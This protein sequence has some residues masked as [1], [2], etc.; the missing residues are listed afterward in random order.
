MIL[1]KKLKKTFV[2]L[3]AFMLIT[4]FA[5]AMF[6][7]TEVLAA[8]ELNIST[9]Y[10]SISV[11]PTD[12]IRTSISIESGNGQPFT[13]DLNVVS[14]PEGWE[15]YF[16]GGSNIIHSI[17]SDGKYAESFY[18]NIRMPY[19][20]P[21]GK[22]KV[23]IKGQSGSASDTL[24]LEYVVEAEMDNQGKLSAN[25][26]ELKGPNDAAFEFQIDIDNNQ[27]EEQIYSLGADV[28]KGWQVNFVPKYETKQIVSL[29]VAPNST[30][31]VQVQITAPP[32]VAAGEYMIPIIA[33]SAIE[34]LTEELK[35]IVTGSYEMQLS[36]PTGRLNAETNAGKET[37]VDLTVTNTGG[38]DLQG[39]K[40]SSWEPDG[41]T[42]EFDTSEIDVIPVGETVDVKAY[43]KPESK[44]I[45]GDYVVQISANTPETTSSAEFRVMVKTSTIWGFVGVIIIILLVVGLYWTFNTY[46]RR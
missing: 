8:S 40:L 39:V 10:P 22:Y 5:L 44:T 20:T 7:F 1:V 41:W 29:T 11:K 2:S 38:S 32:K 6:P 34:S 26:T 13:A 25:Y 16:E 18:L 21:N 31:S 43:I 33:E 9:T 12:K 23:A 42:V 45:A 28:E 4:V 3:M 15:A 30:S 14:L 27:N 17:Y 37:Q 35:V 36:T 24:E 46:G 19:D